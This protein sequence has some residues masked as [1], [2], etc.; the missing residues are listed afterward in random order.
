MYNYLGTEEESSDKHSS[1]EEN[2]DIETIY[3]I[4]SEQR[5]YYIK[6]FQ[7]LQPN[8]TGLI[9]GHIAR[10]FFEKSRIPI[11]ELR[12]IWQL[13]DVTKDGALNLNEFIAAMHLVVLRRNNICLPPAL[14]L[15]LMTTITDEC[16]LPQPTEENL[17]QLSDDER[18]SDSGKDSNQQ[19]FNRT[20]LNNSVGK[21]I[22]PTSD[23][24]RTNK[25]VNSSYKSTS[26]SSSPVRRDISPSGSDTNKSRDWTTF[27]ESPV[28]NICSPKP[29]LFDMQKTV[30]AVGCDPLILH[31][32]PLRV[33]PVASGEALIEHESQ[34]NHTNNLDAAG[35][36][37][38]TRDTPNTTLI[39]NHGND[40]RSIQRPQ[41]KKLPTGIGAIPPPPPQRDSVEFSH[42]QTNSGSSSTSSNTS[43]HNNNMSNS[44]HPIKNDPTPPPPPPR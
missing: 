24:N 4:T 27:N 17:L 28:L 23:N 42:S 1:D 22:D 18:P 29:V 20:N 44:V 43:V 15:C 12:H 39:N 16:T 13:C 3:Q 31:P 8:P 36:K 40:F 9:T 5:E 26:N 19:I 14:P 25:T 37:Y 30:Q 2:A 10:V 35:V 21:L 41:A 7:T 34:N 38:A 32:V 11:K 6:Q 33:T